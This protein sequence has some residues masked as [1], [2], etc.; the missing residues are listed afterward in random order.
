MKKLFIVLLALTL[1]CSFLL[2]G[3]APAPQTDSNTTEP[4]AAPTQ[5]PVQTDNADPSEALFEQG[6]AEVSKLNSVFM[7]G[8]TGGIWAICGAAA[9]DIWQRAFPGLMFTLTPGG[10]VAN[11]EAIQNGSALLAFG[12]SSSTVEGIN[13][14]PAFS[15]PTDKVREMAYMGTEVLQIIVFEDSDIQSVADLKGKILTTSQQGNTVV[16]MAEELLSCYGLKFDDMKQVHYLSINDSVAQMKDGKADCFIVSTSLPASAIL[17]LSSGRKLRMIPLEPDI[18]EKM[19]SINAG[20]MEYVVKPGEYDFV[21]TDIKTIGTSLH[22]AV[23]S[24]LSE[25]AVYAMTKE[26]AENYQ[27]IAA[28]HVMFEGLTPEAMATDIGVEFHPGALKYYQEA[29][30]IK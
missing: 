18:V 16:Q 25:A 21:T 11:M 23:S 14:A 28:V 17:E 3:C 27:N 2:A 24:E 19:R 13:G 29:G 5:A 1:C 6:K 20:Y 4:P 15:A 26:L 22:I 9:A 12:K 8:S 7:T 30:L 10:G